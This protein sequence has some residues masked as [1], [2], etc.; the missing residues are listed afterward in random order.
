MDFSDFKRKI[1]YLL[2]SKMDNIGYPFGRNEL[3]PIRDLVYFAI[4]GKKYDKE[5]SEGRGRGTWVI[6]PCRCRYNN[7]TD[8]DISTFIDRVIKS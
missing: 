6:C 8:N 2:L 3:L 1:E 4:K 5:M 7:I